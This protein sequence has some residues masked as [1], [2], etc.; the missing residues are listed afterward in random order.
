MGLFKTIL[1]SVADSVTD[2][3]GDEVKKGISNKIQEGVI[4]LSRNN[5]T[6]NNN[7]ASRCLCPLL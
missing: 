4:D 3:I 6:V 7:L 1:N 5:D 2:K